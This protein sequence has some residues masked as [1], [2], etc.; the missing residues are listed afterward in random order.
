MVMG[1][2]GA[3]REIIDRRKHCV[4]MLDV[5]TQADAGIAERIDIGVGDIQLGRKLTWAIGKPCIAPARLHNGF[6]DVG[7]FYSYPRHRG[8]LG[9]RYPLDLHVN[10]GKTSPHLDDRSLNILD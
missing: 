10:G 5:A 4:D 1:E 2:L 9:L 8:E 6:C 7:R 3:I